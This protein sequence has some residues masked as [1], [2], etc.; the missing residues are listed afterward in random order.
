VLHGPVAFCHEAPKG[1]YIGSYWPKR[2]RAPFLLG[3]AHRPFI[4]QTRGLPTEPLTGDDVKPLAYFG[5]DTPQLRSDTANYYNCMNRLD[6]LVGDLLEAL[7]RSGKTANTLVVYLGDHG[8][9]L[10]RGKRT[11][12]EGGVRVPLIIRWP[13]KTKPKQVRSELVSTLDLMPTLRP[14]ADAAPVAN[15]PG[16]APEIIER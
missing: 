14:V 5:L 12:Y 3:D 10:L 2:R 4:K 9:D 8:A 7:D 6:T 15:L 1:G 16:L 13:G 11:S